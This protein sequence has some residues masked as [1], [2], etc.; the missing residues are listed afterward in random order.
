MKKWITVWA[1]LAAM[2]ASVYAGRLATANGNAKLIGGSY[3]P[4][5]KA[6]VVAYPSF[7][8]SPGESLDFSYCDFQANGSVSRMIAMDRVGNGGLH[9]VYTKSPNSTHTPRNTAYQYNDRAGSGWS[10]ELDLNTAR[11]GYVTLGVLSDGRE[12]AAFHQAGGGG[13]NQSVVVVG[14]VMTLLDT[15]PLWPHIAVGPTNVIHVVAHHATRAENYYCR[16]TNQGASFTPWQPVAGDTNQNPVSADMIVSRTSGKVAIAWT[17]AVPGGL[18]RQLDMDVVY[19]EST[20]HGATWG[21]MVNVTNYQSADT[22]RAYNDV[23]GIYDPNDNLHLV[24]AG[25]RQEGGNIYTAGAIFHWSQATGIDCI[26]GPGTIPGTWWWSVPANPGTW[27]LCATRPSLSRDTTGRP[28]CVFSSQRNDDD[29]SA[30]GFINMD[31]YGTASQ[32]GGN[33]W[34]PVF[35][36][37]NSHTPGG[38]AGA[39]DDDRFPSL[40]AFTT[41]SMRMFWI[42]DKDAGASVKAEGATTLNPIH[43]LAIRKPPLGV[44]ESNIL[45]PAIPGGFGLGP[46]RPNPAKGMAEFAYALPV[47]RVVDLSVYN[48][49]GQL[50]K[51][52]VSGFKTPGYHM[53]QWDASRVPAGV[54]LY[55]L[56]A[57]EFTKTRTM[58]VVK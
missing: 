43:Y 28:F 3:D 44:E 55:R 24:W 15:G 53:A 36:I 18:H 14:F 1:V 37:T 10:G 58:V 5:G 22:V 27:S 30:G 51:R 48:I 19:I 9:V 45:S 47:P 46:S 41:D 11:A 20:D 34:A 17:R 8:S 6:L 25:H 13:G 35:N 23:S 32:D 26:S 54:Y 39:C 2:A 56:S 31:L 33:T 42:V 49:Q 12:A 4:V 29:S 52:L 21:S 16:S 57:G 38:A 7:L 40:T 50:V